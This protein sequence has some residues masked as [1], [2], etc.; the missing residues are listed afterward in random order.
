M[1]PRLGRHGAPMAAPTKGVDSAYLTKG[2]YLALEQG[3]LLLR[4]ANCLYRSGAFASAVVLAAFAREELGRAGILLDLR[5]NV[6][7][8]E[9]VTPTQ[10]K[11]SCEDHVTKQKW[12]VLS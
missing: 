8:G 3:G 9:V 7:A 6:I 5:A 1:A 11:Q 12:A 10:I 2:A 4:D